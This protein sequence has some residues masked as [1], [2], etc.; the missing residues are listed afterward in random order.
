MAGFSNRP[1]LVIGIGGVGT[2]I[3]IADIMED[4]TGIGYDVVGMCAND[5]LCH[6]AT[7]IAFVD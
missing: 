3:E 7:P 2:K 4:Y 1:Q 5:M 6:C